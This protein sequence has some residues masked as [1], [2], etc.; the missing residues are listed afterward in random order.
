MSAQKLD[1]ATAMMISAD[2][3]ALF[4]VTCDSAT[5]PTPSDKSR[6]IGAWVARI[7]NPGEVVSDLLGARKSDDRTVLRM[8]VNLGVYSKVA[9]LIALLIID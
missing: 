5:A 1:G 6:S 3:A 4:A 2:P 7:L 9:V 8:F